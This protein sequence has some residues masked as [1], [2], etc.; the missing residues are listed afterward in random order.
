MIDIPGLAD[1]PAASLTG[2]FTKTRKKRLPRSC[3]PLSHE[4]SATALGGVSARLSNLAS[5]I[6]RRLSP[7]AKDEDGV[8]D[9][10]EGGGE[11]SPLPARTQLKDEPQRCRSSQ[12]PAGEMVTRR[13]ATMLTILKVRLRSLPCVNQLRGAYLFVPDQILLCGALTCAWSDLSMPNSTV[14]SALLS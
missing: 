1:A 4:A 11:G 9:V 13:G 6:G 7:K 3:L 8:T 14:G 12:F 2:S 5:G 10:E